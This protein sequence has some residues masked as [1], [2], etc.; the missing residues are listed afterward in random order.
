MKTKE[1]GL[2]GLLAEFD[3]PSQVTEAARRTYGE[4]YRKI[5]AYSPFP[6]EELSEAIGFHS[7]RLPQLVFIGGILGGLGGFMMQYYL[8]AYEYPINVGGRPLLSLPSFIPITFELTI[9]LASFT[10]VFGMLALNGLPQPYH[11][12]FNVPSFA[13]ASRDRFFLLIETADPKF[14]AEATRRFL[15][16]LGAREVSDV[17]P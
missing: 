6:I 2:Y 10:A 17:Q 12:V 7:T 8:S 13:L 15:L 9:L 5:D 4:G 1:P 16:S 14:D 3:T 11:P